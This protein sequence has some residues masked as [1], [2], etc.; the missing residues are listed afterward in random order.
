M[1]TEKCVVWTYRVVTHMKPQGLWQYTQELW[2]TKA[3]RGPACMEEVDRKPR[4]SGGSIGNQQ[5]PGEGESAFHTG[6]MVGKLTPKE[7]P[8]HKNT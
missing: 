4:P 3:N 6:M 2:K 8:I 7:R 5:M 1:N